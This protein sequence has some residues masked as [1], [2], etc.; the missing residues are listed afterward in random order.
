[1]NQYQKQQKKRSKLLFSLM[2]L[3]LFKEKGFKETSIQS[4]AKAAEVSPVSIY[5][6]FLIRKI[7]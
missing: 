1:M 3:F 6:Y 2:F 4:I 5:N 7:I